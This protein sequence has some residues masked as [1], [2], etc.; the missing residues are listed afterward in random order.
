MGIEMQ[1]DN[2]KQGPL[3]PEDL[4][5]VQLIQVEML[6]E[7]DRICRLHHINYAMI[8]GTMLGAIRHKGY[9][10]WDDDADIGLLRAEY[11]KFRK[12]CETDLD[13]DRFYFQ[14]MRSTPGYRWGYGKIRRKNTYFLREGQAHM[15]YESGIFID[16]FPFD[17][18]PDG[19]WAE[20]LHN[21][22]CTIIRKILWSEVGK[23][24]DKNPMLRGIFSL[25]SLI[26]LEMVSNHLQR[27][28][29]KF[30]R[31]NGER[32]R[33]ITFPAPDKYSE[34]K[35]EWFEQTAEYP[36]EHLNLLGHYDYNAYLTHKFGDYMILPPEGK[37]KSHP[38]AYYKLLDE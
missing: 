37:R 25:L 21:L 17:S 38:V 22:H 28:T 5:A 34:G 29:E 18:V 23:K 6:A 35:R 24:T 32:V 26:P 3:S 20:K 1:S 10:P 27:F 2:M 14:D 11:E 4:R 36:F 15:P 12:V 7:V 13:P 19:K 9:I 8:G 16:I 31:Q 30:N 33:T